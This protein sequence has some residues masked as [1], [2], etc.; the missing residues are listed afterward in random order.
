MKGSLF[1]SIN[2]ASRFFRHN[3]DTRS[4]KNDGVQPSSKFATSM[5]KAYEVWFRILHP[6]PFSFPCYL[7]TLF[8]LGTA[9][10]KHQELQKSIKIKFGR[11]QIFRFCGRP[12]FISTDAIFESLQTEVIG[13]AVQHTRILF[14][15]VHLRDLRRGM[16]EQVCHLFECQ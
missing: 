4:C 14:Y 8:P 15:I 5:P 16:S 13:N 10:K 2:K 1:H 6:S 9:S 12:F 3:Y 11:P 7:V